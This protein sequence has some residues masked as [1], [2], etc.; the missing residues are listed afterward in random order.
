[1]CWARRFGKE[2]LPSP[3]QK[4]FE[5]DGNTVC[6]KVLDTSVIIDGRVA[7]LCETGFLEGTFLVPHFILDELQHI[8]DSSDSLKR[9]RGRRGLDILNKIQK[10]GDVDVRIIDE[11][12]PHVKEVDAKL[13]VLAKKMNA[14]IVTN[15]LNFNKVAELQGIR[16]LNI[17]E[18]CN[19]LRPVV[20]PGEAI[21]VFVLKEGKEAGQGVAYLDDGTM[22]VVDN[23]RRYIGQERGRHRHQRAADD[24]RP[25]DL[26]P[27]EGRNRARGDAGRAWIAAVSCQACGRAG[28]H[29]AQAPHGT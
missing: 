2:K 11:D 28:S 7:D 17:N 1:M 14:K 26:H 3:E 4:L 20:L 21:R 12:F 29:G 9:A 13:V 19:A 8:A 22:I 10:M 16:V 5:L 15:D 27:A 6:P 18:L 24:C 23:A 25:H